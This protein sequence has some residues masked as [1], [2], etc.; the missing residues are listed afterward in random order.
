VNQHLLKERPPPLLPRGGGVPGKT[1]ASV[2]L[3]LVRVLVQV[4]LARDA[5][6]VLLALLGDAAAA[7]GVHLDDL[8]PPAAPRRR[9]MMPP[10]AGPGEGVNT[11]ERPSVITWHTWHQAVPPPHKKK[12]RSCKVCRRAG[13]RTFISA[14]CWRQFLMMEPL[15]LTKVLVMVP[16]HV[17]SEI[18]IVGEEE[19]WPFR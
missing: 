9:E 15:P 14:N 10:G 4:H 2:L 8:P 17:I 6:Q 11:A 3:L 16:L 7:A 1:D 18:F 5:V 12:R 13:Q 19:N